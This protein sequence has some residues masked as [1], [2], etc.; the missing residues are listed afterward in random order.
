MKPALRALVLALIAALGLTL[1][2][3][4]R[5]QVSVSATPSA[6][7]VEVGQSFRVELTATARGQ[8]QPGDPRL[9]VPS[10]VSVN[11]PSIGTRTQVSLGMGGM[12]QTVSTTA[13]WVLVASRVGK[14][15]LGPPSVEAG[16][17]RYEG[18]PLLI[19]V[20][21]QGS[22]PA[23]PPRRASP[24][25]PFGMFDPFGGGSPFP[26]GVFGQEPPN[27]PEEL[28][29]VP[30]EFRV[31]QAPDPSAF[32]RAVA[33][34]RRVVVG[35]QVTLKIYA[36]GGRGQFGLGNP[37]E[38][39][40][41]DFLSFDLDD[42]ASNQVF[43]RV[44][45]GDSI[46]YAVKV[47][48]YALF[49]LHSGKL[50]I[51]PM[52]L[53][54]DGGR[55]RS[56]TPLVRSSNAVEIEV[57]EPPLAGRPP[58]YRIG[59]VGVLSLAVE[60]TPRRAIAGDAVS[61][62]AKLEGTGNL[63]NALVIPQKRGV[64]WL[65]PTL[66]SAIDTKRGVVGGSRSFTYVVKLKEPGTIDL[67]ELTL[68][69]FDPKLRSYAVARAALGSIEV[70]PNPKSAA[71]I[72]ETT[73]PAGAAAPRARKSLGSF[74]RAPAPFTDDG[75]FWMLLLGAPFAVL[76]AGA[77]LELGQRAKKAMAAAR[78]GPERLAQE[79]LRAAEVSARSEQVA[80]TAGSI[81]RALFCAIE[82]A[83]GIRGR[84]LLKGE[85]AEKL[86]ELGLPEATRAQALELIDAC[87]NA[88]FTGKSGELPP[89]VLL[90]KARTL[91]A[92]LAR[93]RRP[94]G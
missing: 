94:K 5:A 74:K 36:Y 84:G 12:R 85:L 8:D 53:Q 45:I 26:P 63:P 15:R 22:L 87:E 2:G 30:E 61:V 50:T 31:E 77:G 14:L 38:A 82:G 39:S 67:G 10:G 56:R 71:K 47:A 21:P 49:P 37:K 65:D 54:F 62:V 28:P 91:V 24:F 33:T 89:R 48:D 78:S 79:A 80:A 88:R 40:R 72:A 60:V 64:D 86:G 58:G 93:R 44:P 51:G 73:G 16:G 69:Y 32:L 83:T 59:D 46:Y 19:E 52:S 76:L 6:S 90:E 13:T 66:A 42:P 92:E 11:G 41:P 70:Q 17:R 4:A 18:N 1:S 9:P 43:V 27:Q 75:R 34:P 29:P 3:N 20:V 25:D 7:K 55:Y 23:P 81:E 35:E 68:P 57:E